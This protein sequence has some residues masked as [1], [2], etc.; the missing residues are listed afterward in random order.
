MIMIYCWYNFDGVKLIDTSGTHNHIT[1]IKKK[2][3]LFYFFINKMD[4]TFYQMINNIRSH[5]I[6]WKIPKVLPRFTHI[7]AVS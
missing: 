7:D 2:I 6:W 4:P 1:W 5:L 3:K